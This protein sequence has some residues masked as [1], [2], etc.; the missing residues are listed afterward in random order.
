MRVCDT[1]Y[2]HSD[3]FD[4]KKKTKHG[5]VSAQECDVMISV[6]GSKLYDSH[7]WEE[8]HING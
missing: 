1:Y 6:V 8:Q 7:L 4:H 2:V 3:L 5:N